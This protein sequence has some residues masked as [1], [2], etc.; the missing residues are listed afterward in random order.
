MTSMSLQWHD[1][2]LFT[3]NILWCEEKYAYS[4]KIA[5]FF[6]ATT[7]IP[8]VSIG[9]YYLLKTQRLRLGKRYTLCYAFLCL[10]GIGSFLFH[11]TLR[12]EAQLL[13]ELPMMLMA[14]QAIWCMGVNGHNDTSLNILNAVLIYGF[15]AAGALVYLLWHNYWVF[16]LIFA[17]ITALVIMGSFQLCTKYSHIVYPMK[18]SFWLNLF[19]LALWNIDVHLCQQLRSARLMVGQPLDAFLQLHAWWHLLTALGLVWFVTG[20]VM[21]NPSHR[22]YELSTRLWSFPILSTAKGSLTEK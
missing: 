3:A 1:G 15:I 19:A 9:L 14:G 20:L 4:T 11:A 17:G 7:N 21:A 13:D 18:V 2:H 5:E 6:N 10:I 22:H 12:K 16:H 8:F